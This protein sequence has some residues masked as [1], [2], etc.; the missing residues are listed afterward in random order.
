MSITE[1]FGR[2]FA[3]IACAAS[4]WQPRSPQT[5][6]LPAGVGALRV[7]HRD[8]RLQRRG[9]QKCFANSRV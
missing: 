7:D 8:V 5:W 2:H 4:F 9:G 6:V 3:M 1:M